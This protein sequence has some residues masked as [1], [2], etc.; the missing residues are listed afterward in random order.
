M[1]K[2]W[3]SG[4]KSSEAID[5]LRAQIEELERKRDE[6]TEKNKRMLFE[7]GSFAMTSNAAPTTVGELRAHAASQEVREVLAIYEL[8]N[9][10]ILDKQSLLNEKLDEQARYDSMG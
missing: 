10:Q 5:R 8:L 2:S 9:Q 7:W 6:L 1:N 3:V 4:G